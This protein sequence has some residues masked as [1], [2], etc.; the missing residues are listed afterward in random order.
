MPVTLLLNNP[1]ACSFAGYKLKI[2]KIDE[3]Y[4]KKPFLQFSA[5][6]YMNQLKNLFLF[7]SFGTDSPPNCLL[8]E[9]FY[10]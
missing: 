3:K 7:P 5:K 6:A 9:R 1:F 10:T 4:S 2:A 8:F